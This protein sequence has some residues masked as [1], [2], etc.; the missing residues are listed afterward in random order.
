MKSIILKIQKQRLFD[1]DLVKNGKI[2]NRIKHTFFHRNLKTWQ[3]NET[4]MP[5]F[6]KVT[7]L[8]F[9]LGGYYEFYVDL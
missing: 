1:D 7:I 2:K 9:T 3:L 6:L 8:T 5:S 4:Q